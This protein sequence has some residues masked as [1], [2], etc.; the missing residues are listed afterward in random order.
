MSRRTRRTV[1][2]H[3]FPNVKFHDGVPLTSADVLFTY[4]RIIEKNY[5]Y[6]AFLRNVESM[7]APDAMTI[8]FHLK[9]PDM[10]LV[11]MMAQAADWN[12]KI[13]PKHLWEKEAGFDTGPYV[14]KPI[15][16][17]ARSGLCGGNKALSKWKPSRII[18]A[19][20]RRSID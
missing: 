11:P 4:D 6:A 20:S 12:G 7:D 13:Y 8:V 2:F 9:T 16:S 10:A 17:A 15:G 18:S 5:P 14:N 1:T 19:A 3:L